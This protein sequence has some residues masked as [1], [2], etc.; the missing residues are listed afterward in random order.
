MGMCKRNCSFCVED[1]FNEVMLTVFTSVTCV[2]RVLILSLL[3]LKAV[4]FMG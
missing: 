2:K 4:F 3:F 1:C